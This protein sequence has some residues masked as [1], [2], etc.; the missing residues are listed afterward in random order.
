MVKMTETKVKILELMQ[1]NENPVHYKQIIEKL[2][3]KPRATNMHIRWLLK[4]GY[5]TKV[6]FHEYTLTSSGREAIGFPKTDEKLAKKV[7]GKTSREKAFHFYKGIDQP[8]GVTSDSLTDFCEKLMTVDAIIVEFHTKRG[9][10]ETWIASLGDIELARKLKVIRETKLTGEALHKKI[11]ETVKS[12][13]NELL[14][15]K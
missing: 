4:D 6:Q 11:Y 15:A 5:I 13:C 12:R 3:L 10:F 1:V 8:T 2:G 9:D 7:L 14:N